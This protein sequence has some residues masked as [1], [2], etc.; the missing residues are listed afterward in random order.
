[1]DKYAE[2]GILNIEDSNI[3]EL[4]PFNLIGKKAKIMKLFNGPVGYRAMLAELEQ[5]LYNIA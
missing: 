4:S 3:L 2:T 1:M 5:Q